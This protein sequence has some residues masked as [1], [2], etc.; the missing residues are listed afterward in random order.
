MPGILGRKL[1]MTRI[2]E[3]DGKV[4]P[5]TLIRCT[6][7]TAVRLKTKEKDQYEAIVLGFEPLKKTTKTKKFR[8]TKEFRLNKGTWPKTEDIKLTE[9]VTVESFKEVKEVTVTGIS[10]GKGFQGTI[11][12]FHFSA[13]PRSHGSHFHREPGSIGPRARMGKLHKGKKLAG[14]MGG[15]TVTL[16]HVPLI[17]IDVEKNLLAV[18]GQVPG[19][20]GGL[21]MIRN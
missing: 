13:G 1:G 21:V 10:K 2:F 17:S 7:N 4:I 12:R 9:P 8:A 20:K 11:K 5:V 6:P 16:K 14:H 15:D 3:E 19:A 18:K